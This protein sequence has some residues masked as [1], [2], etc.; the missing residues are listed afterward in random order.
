[1]DKKDIFGRLVFDR[2]RFK[3]ITDHYII[4]NYDMYQEYNIKAVLVDFS[5]M[6]LNESY[7]YSE[8]FEQL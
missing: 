8:Y 6:K 5:K 1:M 2:N 7:Y 3:Y 4:L